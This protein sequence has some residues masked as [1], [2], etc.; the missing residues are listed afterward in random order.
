M[1]SDEQVQ[2]LATALAPHIGYASA[3]EISK[4]SVKEGVLIREMVKR[5]G[6]LPPTLN[7]HQTDEPCE[8]D[9]VPRE[10]KQKALRYAISNSF[11]FGGTNAA[12]VLGR[13]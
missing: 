5:D 3:A 13:A 9:L 8:I 6:I 4:K 12:L 2:A 10:A 11:G 7:L 1:T